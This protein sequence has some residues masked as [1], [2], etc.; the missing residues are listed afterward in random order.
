MDTRPAEALNAG[1]LDLT[2]PAPPCGGKLAEAGKRG[3]DAPGG[4]RGEN[5]VSGRQPAAAHAVNVCFGDYSSG[6]GRCAT[7]DFSCPGSG[8]F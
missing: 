4:G 7:G 8:V 5:E 1:A 2:S 3:F 6:K